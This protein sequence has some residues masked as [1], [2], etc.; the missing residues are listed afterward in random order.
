MDQNRQHLTHGLCS[1]C[2]GI[3]L[4]RPD[5]WGK[6]YPIADIVAGFKI[7][8]QFCGLLTFSLDLKQCMAKTEDVSNTYVSLKDS[9]AEDNNC[10]IA[11]LRGYFETKRAIFDIAII[12]KHIKSPEHGK[13][14]KKLCQT[15][16]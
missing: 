2:F 5:L 13:I 9:G 3:D 1:T 11:E 15:Y 12:Q 7:G 8:C 10:I 6:P 14:T 16:I 4:D